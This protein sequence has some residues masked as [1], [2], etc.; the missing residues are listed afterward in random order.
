MSEGAE[1]WAVTWRPRGWRLGLALA[2]LAVVYFLAGKLALALAFVNASTSAVWPPTGIALAAFLLLG[3]RVWPAILVG[4][5]LVNWT[6][7]G[8]AATSVVIATGN[9]LEG[10]LGAAL[11]RRF[12][13]G[14]AVFDRPWSIARFVF[15]AAG[16][17]AAVSATFGATSLVL[18]GHARWEHYAP[19]WVTWWLGD[20]TGAL[21]VTPVLLLWAVE[22]VQRWDRAKALEALALAAGLLF[23]CLVGFAGWTPPGWSV[24]PAVSF[25]CFPFPLWVAFRFSRREVSLVTLLLSG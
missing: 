21:V 15:L 16:I 9:T 6:T 11:V 23:T 14:S 7:T 5:F 12:A 19:I 8:S 2:A 17:A 4:A 25:L 3:V 24:N 22:R 10:L 20:A 18:G 1:T 13:G